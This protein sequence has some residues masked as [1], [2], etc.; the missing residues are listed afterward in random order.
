MNLA[1]YL[2]HSTNTEN[3]VTDQMSFVACSVQVQF[4]VTNT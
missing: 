4:H 3:A 2:Y 1:L